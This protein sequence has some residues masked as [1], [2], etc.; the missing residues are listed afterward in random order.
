M[1]KR[2]IRPNGFFGLPF[3]LFVS[4][5][6]Y[7]GTKSFTE[8][9]SD[10]EFLVI[11]DNRLRNLT[12]FKVRTTTFFSDLIPFLGSCIL[13]FIQAIK[14]SH[15]LSFFSSLNRTNP[16]LMRLFGCIR[17]WSH[18]LSWTGVR[19]TLTNLDMDAAEASGRTGNLYV[20]W[21]QKV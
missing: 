9:V 11:R 16:S 20:I 7:Q 19:V 14:C 8:L 12:K 5:C 15:L 4:V 2:N 6:C 17:F 18:L 13:G 10:P 21:H 3:C 1:A